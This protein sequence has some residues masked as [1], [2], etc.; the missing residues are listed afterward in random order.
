MKARNARMAPTTMKTVP[1]GR[2]ECCMKGA[3]RVGGTVTVTAGIPVLGSLGGAPATA[4]VLTEPSA[5]VM[6]TTTWE[7]VE[8]V[9]ATPVLAEVAIE[10][11]M[12]TVEACAVVEGGVVLGLA[13]V[14]WAEVVASPPVLREGKAVLGFWARVVERR[15]VRRRREVVVV[16]CIVTVCLF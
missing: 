4:V 7:V 3:L 12:R 14:D 1:S 15:V 2:L 16:R 8:I 11:V 9:G 10:A 5:P 13:D 6:L